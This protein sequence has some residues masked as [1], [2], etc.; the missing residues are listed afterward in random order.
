MSERFQ[1]R[2]EV[3]NSIREEISGAR[4]RLKAAREGLS[5]LETPRGIID[6]DR[7]LRP[8]RRKVKVYAAKYEVESEASEVEALED[9]LEFLERFK[10]VEWGE[11]ITWKDASGMNYFVSTIEGK[12][13]GKSLRLY[14]FFQYENSEYP[15]RDWYE[16][17]YAGFV[18]E[19][20]VS[21]KKVEE[22]FSDGARALGSFHV[23][24]KEQTSLDSSEFKDIWEYWDQISK[25]RP[26]TTDHSN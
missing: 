4:N 25:P 23:E 26:K 11:Q 7:L 17:K 2:G 21:P 6:I 16:E 3:L 5:S 19:E 10:E 9:N 14:R 8:K 18:D 13:Q 24:E 20:G 15:F 12:L 22:L 1:Q